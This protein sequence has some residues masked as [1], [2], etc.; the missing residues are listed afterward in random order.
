[1]SETQRKSMRTLLHFV[2][3]ASSEMLCKALLL[4][5][6]ALVLDLEDSV[7]PDNKD[8]ARTTIVDWLKNIDSG[9][10]ERIVQIDALD[11]KWSIADVDVSDMF[12]LTEDKKRCTPTYPAKEMATACYI[13]TNVPNHK[14]VWSA[15]FNPSGA[16]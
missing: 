7:T 5:A 2:P 13:S 16:H 8:S 6:D 4:K 3:Y 12:P 14:S 1:M 9:P 10:R 11:S 15:S